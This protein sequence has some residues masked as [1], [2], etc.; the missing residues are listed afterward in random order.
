M[1]PGPSGEI[2]GEGKSGLIVG[3]RCGKTSG[4]S[5]GPGDGVWGSGPISF[6]CPAFIAKTVPGAIGADDWL[7]LCNP[8]G[9]VVFNSVSKENRAHDPEFAEAV[10]SCP[11]F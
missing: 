8:S 4:D 10:R 3:D 5:S 11:A 7:Q 1:R 6:I 2:S 9:I